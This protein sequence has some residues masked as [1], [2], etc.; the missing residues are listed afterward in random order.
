MP[1]ELLSQQI[2]SLSGDLQ[3]LRLSLTARQR[4]VLLWPKGQYLVSTSTAV[5]TIVKQRTGREKMG[6]LIMNNENK[7]ALSLKQAIF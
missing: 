7:Q 5:S 2:A 1:K 4:W 3:H 6:K